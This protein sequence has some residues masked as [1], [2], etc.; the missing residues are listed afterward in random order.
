M[1][2]SLV[3][4]ICCVGTL[5]KF[6]TRYCSVMPLCC[7]SALLSLACLRKKGDIK[8]QYYI[9]LY[10]I[11]I[12][13][14]ANVFI[15][16]WMLVCLDACLLGC[17]YVWMYEWMDVWMHRWMYVWMYVCMDVCMYGCMYVCMDI[18]M[19]GCMYLCIANGTIS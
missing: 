11:Y 18:C 9:V 4:D 15:V 19:Y 17:M 2:W 16:V 5:S 7:V 6:F 10:C 1:D 13:M 12:L 8:D 14:R 3:W